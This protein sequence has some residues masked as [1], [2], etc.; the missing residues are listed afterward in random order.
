MPAVWI[1]DGPPPCAHD[2]LAVVLSCPHLTRYAVIERH[3]AWLVVNTSKGV[4]HRNHSLSQASKI[5]GH[6]AF[7]ITH[8]HATVI[9][10]RT[11]HI[12]HHTH[13]G[14]GGAVELASVLTAATILAD[15]TVTPTVSDPVC[16]GCL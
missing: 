11:S 5:Y 14:G 13:C 1:T 8:L 16:D 7:Q 6:M 4:F 15:A 2:H 3:S 9:S 10:G 12:Q